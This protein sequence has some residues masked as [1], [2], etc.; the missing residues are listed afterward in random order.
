MINT[1]H[2][3][4]RM[5]TRTFAVEAVGFGCKDD[6]T[7]FVAA[8]ISRT[9]VSI[10]TPK[11]IQHMTV[12]DVWLVVAMIALVAKG[13]VYCFADVTRPISISYRAPEVV[14]WNER[15]VNDG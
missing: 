14:L 3:A 15:P 4:W 1:L 9:Y 6:T 11:L 12:Q 5:L 10:I 2:Y 7:T 13:K 8:P